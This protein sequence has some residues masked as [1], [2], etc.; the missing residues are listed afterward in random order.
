MK[1][2]ISL[3]FSFYLLASFVKSQGLIEE[4]LKLPAPPPPNPAWKESKIN[5]VNFDPSNPPD[6]D[7]NPED[8]IAYFENVGQNWHKK[9]P[10]EKIIQ[11]IKAEIE[12]DP[13]QLLS[14]LNLFKYKKEDVDFVKD[15]YEKE[16]Q[17]GDI[18]AFWRKEVL[19]WLVLNSPYFTDKLVSLVQAKLKEAYGYVEG[20]EELLALV[21][22]DWSKAK[23]ILNRLI[24]SDQEILQTLAKYAFYERAIYEQNDLEIK[25]WRDELKKVVE[26]KTKKAASRDLAIDALF[27]NDDFPGR[28]EWY[29][30]LFSDETLHDLRDDEI[31]FTGLITPV[32]VSSPDKYKSKLLEFLKSENKSLR[33]IAARCLTEIQDSKTSDPE[34]VKALLNLLEQ[35]DWVDEKWKESLKSWLITKLSEIRLPESVPGLIREFQEKRSLTQLSNKDLLMLMHTISALGNQRASEAAPLLRSFL[36]EVVGRDEIWFKGI[37]VEAI[38]KCRGF[39][40]QEEAV[41]IEA[42]LKVKGNYPETFET[43]VGQQ[44]DYLYE[45]ENANTETVNLLYLRSKTLSKTDPELSFNIRQRLLQ[46]KG[47]FIDSLLLSELKEGSLESEGILR[48]LAKR[49]ELRQSKLGEI[50]SL[51]SANSLTLGISSCLLEDYFPVI[52]SNDNQAKLAMLACA[53]LIRAK[54]PVADVIQMSANENLKIAALKF[55][56]ADDSREARNFIY[57]QYPGKAYVT[58]ARGYFGNTSSESIWL[59]KVFESVYEDYDPFHLTGS[60]EKLKRIEKSLQEEVLKEK[61]LTIYAWNN[62]YVKV[63]KDRII[64]QWET[65][66][67]YYRERELEKEEFETLRNF[68]IENQAWDLPPFLGTCQEDSCCGPLPIN[69]ELLIINKDGGRRVFLSTT[70][71]FSKVPFF[72]DLEKIFEQF[73]QKKA[74]LKYRSQTFVPQLKISFSSDDIKILNV[75]KN[76]SDFRVFVVNPKAQESALKQINVKISELEEAGVDEKTIK[77]TIAKELMSQEW[78]NSPWRRFSDG[79]I[80][81]KVATPAIF[82]PSFGKIPIIQEPNFHFR[83]WKLQSSAFHLIEEDDGLYKVSKDGRRKKISSKNYGGTLSISS[84]GRWAVGLSINEGKLFRLN[85]VTGRETPIFI[86]DEIQKEYL[87]SQTYYISSLDKFLLAA[88][89]DNLEDYS[90]K[91]EEEFFSSGLGSEIIDP[92]EDCCE[93]FLLDAKTWKLEKTTSKIKLFAHQTVRPLQKASTGEAEFWV[94]EFDEKE[95]KTNI[96]ILNAK[97]QELKIV[98]SIP[99]I[100]FNSMR[101]WVDE[102]QKTAYI[103]HDGNLLEVPLP[104]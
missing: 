23:P 81:E 33:T 78:I 50:Y 94:A 79:K 2:I 99:K 34:I 73:R 44:I 75:W 71:D 22:Q 5:V 13:Y 21:R 103:V 53:R 20:K 24:A 17:K 52:N 54:L 29:L 69:T 72:K 6:E 19:N 32:K 86:P 88:Y 58:G 1:K 90:E 42:W 15:I 51:R 85:L 36:T 43:I 11:K 70:K 63:Y 87:F 93:S 35:P 59:S 92:D 102:T 96:G 76:G 56:E 60:Y 38:V 62:N 31:A 95:K 26:D 55:L 18:D 68:L 47:D 65:S 14:L 30:S 66:E 48:L 89:K 8:L 39:S 104:L 7:S 4:L 61:D 97:T 37:I 64:F 27:L 80:M 101:M 25:R 100:K 82:S 77:E 28:N 91:T 9:R 67:D 46:W 10:S 41:F 84:D 57:S 16:T 45:R 83:Q 12:K 98:L 49:H 40:A 3:M 74:V